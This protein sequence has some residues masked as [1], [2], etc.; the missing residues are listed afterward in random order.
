MSE[1]LRGVVVSHD[2]LAEALVRTV[3]RITG[4]D[5]GLAALT[6][7]GTTRE[8][9]CADIAGAVGD[10][11]AVV[12]VDLPGGSC[13]HAVLTEV[14]A[15]ANV[16]VVGGV[17]LPMLL[18]FVYHRDATPQAAAERAINKGGAAMRQLQP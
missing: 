17:N 2:G 6:N 16:T 9:L 10:A 7:D 11:P 5:G 3:A 13:L 8:S 15:R 1:L 4:D 18:D 12:F 14:R